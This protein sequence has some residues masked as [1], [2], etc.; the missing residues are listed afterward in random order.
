M[1]DAI[2]STSP[3]GGT[4]AVGVET[5]ADVAVAGADVAVAGAGVTVLPPQEERRTL[6]AINITIRIFHLGY[7]ALSPY[8][9]MSELYST[10]S[11]Q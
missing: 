7:I 10:E 9:E 1:A 3:L 6:A 5:G 4:V 8:F 2:V 11:M